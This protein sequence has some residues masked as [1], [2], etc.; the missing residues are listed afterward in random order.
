M[1]RM[2][3]EEDQEEEEEQAARGQGCVGVIRVEKSKLTGDR[4]SRIRTERKEPDQ[5]GIRLS[6]LL[7]PHFL[8]PPV[9]PHLILLNFS[10]PSHASAS[11]HTDS[12]PHL[13]WDSYT[14]LPIIQKSPPF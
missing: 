10:V 3:M 1:R 11:L 12:I 5:G 8:I 9:S 14:Y 2:K 6:F 13:L 7:F 4:H